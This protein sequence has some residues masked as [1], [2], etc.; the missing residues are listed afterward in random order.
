MIEI[1]TGA[2][3]G[4]DLLVVPVLADRTP[5]P[6]AAAVVDL[7][8]L[9]PLLD[10]KDFTGKVGQSLFVQTPAGP[11]PELLLIGLGEDVD[12]EGL[13][14][15]AGS[16]ARAASRYAT[17]ATLLHAVNIEGASSAVVLGTQ[18]GAYSFDEYRS[19]PKERAFSTLVLVGDEVDDG[20]IRQANALA[21]GVSLARDLVN[22]PAA[23]KPPAAIA[24][25]ATGLHR[26]VSVTVY[27]ERQ[28][29]EMGFGGLVAVNRGSDRPARM[30]VME[31]RPEGA[32]RTVA[33]VGK[34]IV[35]DSGGL[36]IKSAANME[37]M[38][39]DMAGAAAVMGA[40][41]AIA[42]VGLVVNVIGIAP[43]TENLTGGSATRPGDVMRAYNGKTIEILNTDAEGRLVLADGL[44]LAAEKGP[45]LIVDIATLTGACK[46]ALGPS[47]GGLFA[48]ND[49]AATTV[50]SAAESAGEKF[51]RL[52]IDKEY[53]SL[54][55]SD[56]A[57]MKNTG[58]G[59]GGAI[60][61]ALILSEFVGDV[62]WVHLDVAG[63]ARADSTEHYVS[64]G[65]SG[66]GVR[67]LYAIA[68]ALAD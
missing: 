5:V 45:D 35:F 18:L 22:R 68:E 64:K 31:Y 57:D 44:S 9:R 26:D 8:S 63:P 46:V 30:V 66:F 27:D 43:L 25:I 17:V 7:E 11:A 16:A 54:V 21:N 42:E 28:I 34:G 50:A 13:R 56:I 61:A 12:A 47:I 59:W 51:W 1:V 55:D 15:A 29:E 53:R 60:L 23:D 20:D 41:Q 67:T 6:A 2:T 48:I 36:S 19:E 24:D 39:T 33:F 14:R 52:P 38:K 62:P 58:G 40:V 49:E 32:S 65:A 37:T 10:A 3:E 4:A